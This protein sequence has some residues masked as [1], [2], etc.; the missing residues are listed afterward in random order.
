MWAKGTA[1]RVRM[2]QSL[3]GDVVGSTYNNINFSFIGKP[4]IR[5]VLKDV[6]VKEGDSLTL[7]VEVYSTPEADVKW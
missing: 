7:E 6:E 1:G 4:K 3:L 5:R 2:M